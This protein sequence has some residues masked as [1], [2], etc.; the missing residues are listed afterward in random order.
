MVI[1]TRSRNFVQLLHSFIR[2]FVIAFVTL[3]AWPCMSQLHAVTWCLLSLSSLVIVL[4]ETSLV[5]NSCFSA[6]ICGQ[7]VIGVGSSIGI[8]IGFK[9]AF[10]ARFVFFIS[11]Y[12]GR[13]KP[14]LRRIY[15]HSHPGTFP[16]PVSNRASYFRSSNNPARD[17]RTHIFPMVPQ[18]LV[19]CPMIWCIAGVSKS[20]GAFSF[21]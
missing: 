13:N 2:N 10:F 3:C 19:C 4:D 12:T 17:I 5:N 6:G 21:R 9:L 7:Q 15:Q 20:L 8:H 11:T 1:Q 18:D 16:H 14:L